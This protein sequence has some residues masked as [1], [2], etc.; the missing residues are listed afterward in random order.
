[1]AFRMQSISPIPAPD[2]N[3]DSVGQE[4]FD[5][6]LNAVT[7]M[8]IRRA[9]AHDPSKNNLNWGS[10]MRRSANGLQVAE[11]HGVIMQ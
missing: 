10:F 3:P 2:A 6:V 9:L 11:H 1:M 5:W 7:D 4:N 8:A